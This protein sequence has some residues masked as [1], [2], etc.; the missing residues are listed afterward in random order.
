MAKF[1]AL[2]ASGLAV[3]AVLAL[4][5]MGFVVLH[6]A[7]GVMNFAHGDLVTL[8]AYLALWANVSL[9]LPI[10]AAY[11]LSIV[12]L[13]GIGVL[14]ERVAYAPLRRRSP[15][16]VIVATLAA[17]IVIEGLISVWQGATPKSLSSP[18]SN[19]VVTVLGAH[20]PAQDFLVLGVAT[21]A[22][23]GLVLLFHRT[24][25]GRSIR[26][27]AFDPETAQLQGIR[28][29]AISM[30]AF[31]LS[32][33]LAALAGVLIGPLSS[34]NLT[35]GFDLMVTGFAAAVLGGFGSLGGVLAGSMLLGLVQQVLGDYLWASY[36]TTLP[37]VVMLLVITL[38][39][40]G[41]ITLQRSRL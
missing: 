24:G 3:G 36:S 19:D 12:I 35:F 40:S 15:T 6:K 7:T 30:V 34:I 4:V 28:V 41:L 38:R 8:G 39:P 17:A 10:V 27:M 1:I 2:L 16:T 29:R 37:F 25:F 23:G 5:S 18:V 14:I 9:S 11:C 21:L 31:G 33:G 13:L 32:A 20:V 26:A 22:I